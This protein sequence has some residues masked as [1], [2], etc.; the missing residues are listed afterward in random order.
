M[1]GRGGKLIFHG[2]GE[3]MGILAAQWPG[4]GLRSHAG[5]RVKR[6]P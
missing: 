5:G 1:A 4:A 2:R 6:A 3:L